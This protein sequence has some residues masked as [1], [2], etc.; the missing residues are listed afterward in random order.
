[1]DEQTK[2][3]KELKKQ[4]SP[5][6]K[7]ANF[8]YYYK[9][10]VFVVIF[11]V[12]VIALTV[13]EIVTKVEDDLTVTYFSNTSI[14]NE[15]VTKLTDFI[16]QFTKDIDGDAESMVSISPISGSLSDGGEQSVAAQTKYAAEI[17][18][19]HSMGF[20]V[21]RAYF[22]AINKAYPE[23]IQEYC[24]IT[25]N[26]AVAELFG[27]EAD[28]ELYWITKALY[29]SELNK[30]KRIAMNENAHRVYQALTS[31]VEAPASEALPKGGNE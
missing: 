14:S 25:D 21:D 19:G 27:I 29:N 20:I 30:E 22:D 6:E 10:H 28:E 18:S 13:Y 26:E 24:L 7:R 17:G 3:G 16:T 15:R 23:I 8:W 1:M 9:I 12:V 11:A 5:K 31:K 4:L 2:R